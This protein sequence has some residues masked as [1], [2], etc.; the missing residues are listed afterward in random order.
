MKFMWPDVLNLKSEVSSAANLDLAPSKERYSNL[1]IAVILLGLICLFFFPAVFQGKFLAPLDY[2]CQDIIWV[3]QCKKFGIT[4]I[5]NLEIG[6]DQASQF[7]N[8]YVLTRRLWQSGT[9]PLW[10]PY[11]Y[12]GHPLLANSQSA[13]FYPINLLILLFP[14]SIAYTISAIIRMFVAGWFTYLFGI[15]IKLSKLASLLAAIAFTFSGPLV[16]W[17]G[18]PHSNVIVWMPALFYLTE[19]F[20]NY[21]KSKYVIWLGCT[22]GVQGLGGHPETLF[23]IIAAWGLYLLLR[24]F[25]IFRSREKD[26]KHIFFY[27]GGF[28]LAAILGMSLAAIQILPTLEAIPRS[29]AFHFREYSPPHIPITGRA[30]FH[31]YINL[32]LFLWPNFYGNPADGQSAIRITYQSYIEATTY[33]GV[34][35]VLFSFLSLLH[36]EIR[37]LAFV[38]LSMTTVILGIA[39]R[40]PI[41]DLVNYLPGFNISANTRLRLVAVF[42]LAILGGIGLDALQWLIHHKKRRLTFLLLGIAL[43]LLIITVEKEYVLSL[44]HALPQKAL[45]V[46]TLADDLMPP[47]IVIV[48][49]GALQFFKSAK[50]LHAQRVVVLLTVIDLFWAGSRF[51]TFVNPALDISQFRTDFEIVS[52]IEK[53]IKKFDKIASTGTIMLPNSAS[54]LQMFNVQGYDPMIFHRYYEFFE[55]FGHIDPYGPGGFRISYIAAENTE[56]INPTSIAPLR[57]LGVNY[58][59]LHSKLGILKIFEDPEALPRAFLVHQV[60]SQSADQVLATLWNPDFVPGHQALIEEEPPAEWINSTSTQQGVIPANIISYQPNEVTIEVSSPDPVFLVFSD[61]YDPGWRGFIDDR[62]TKIYL[63]NYIMRGIFIAPGNHKVRFVYWP[64]TFIIGASITGFTV[65][66]IIIWLVIQL[67]QSKSQRSLPVYEGSGNGNPR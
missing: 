12:G 22:F 50:Y 5:H 66:A 24:F 49:G 32:L 55:R 16:S 4:T 19:K 43:L 30:A 67:L 48:L 20:L 36:R 14:L 8:W 6:G 45:P 47:A 60:T 37:Q 57:L 13:V 38:S 23:H 56:N 10:N 40:Y 51:N 53:K 27:L 1:I 21:P 44:V 25:L 31:E 64:L 52:T 33:I 61:T 3:E 39:F 54:A 9:V 42:F 35:P 11:N 62:E 41:F 58:Y 63:T 2:L 18:H 28:C 29:F 34:L 17:L 7:Y 59:L 15:N 26:L 65:V 46:S